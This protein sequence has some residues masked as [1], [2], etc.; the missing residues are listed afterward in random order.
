MTGRLAGACAWLTLGAL[1][2][3]C[4]HG[5]ASSANRGASSTTVAIGASS[6]AKATGETAPTLAGG[7]ALPA[8]KAPSTVTSSLSSTATGISPGTGPGAT[9]AARAGFDAWLQALADG[10]TTTALADSS[11][12]AQALG[13]VA[14]VVD[15]AF[16]ADGATASTKVSSQ[17]LSPIAASAQEVDFSGEVVLGHTLSGPKGSTSN[18]DK[19]DGPIKVIAK[20][21]SWQVENFTYDGQLLLLYTQGSS[22][23][24]NGVTLVVAFVESL[25]NATVA[26][27]KLTANGPLP[28]D[29]EKVSLTLGSGAAVVGTAQFGKGMS[30]GELDFPRITGAPAHLDVTVKRGPGATPFDLSMALHGR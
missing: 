19:I 25:G 2:A 10:D 1:L 12:P 29:I 5:H 16:T 11:G 24:V 15:E 14:I 27:V 4:S 8:S 13:A 20:S 28:V 26:L 9:S 7:V 18:Q 23:S 17:S 30:V 22:T 6:T 21:G 3:A